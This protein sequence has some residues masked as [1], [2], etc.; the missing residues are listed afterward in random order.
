MEALD[1][2]GVWAKA[3]IMSADSEGFSV[4]FVGYSSKWNRTVERTELRTPTL[5][6]D[7]DHTESQTKSKRR[8]GPSEE[9]RAE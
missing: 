3:Q 5:T 6:A 1:E 7:R 2:F 4:K 9:V 8:R